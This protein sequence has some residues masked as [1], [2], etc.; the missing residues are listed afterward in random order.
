MLIL[1][2]VKVV[3]PLYGRATSSTTVI[4]GPQEAGEGRRPPPREGYMSAWQVSSFGAIEN[5]QLNHVPIPILKKPNDILV[6]VMSSSVNPL[7]IYMTGKSGGREIIVSLLIH[8]SPVGR[9]DSRKL[10]AYIDAIFA[11]IQYRAYVGEN[12]I[13][14][15]FF[16]N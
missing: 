12:I 16:G 14:I 15:S 10:I 7:D 4:E 5:L 11:L 13:I 6:K 2:R 9:A 8:Y 3:T 1:R